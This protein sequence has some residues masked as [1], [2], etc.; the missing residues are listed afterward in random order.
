MDLLDELGIFVDD[1]ANWNNGAPMSEEDEE[2]LRIRMLLH[3]QTG[4]SKDDPEDNV[5]YFQYPLRDGT[6]SSCIHVN[7]QTMDPGK[8]ELPSVAHPD[9]GPVSSSYSAYLHAVYGWR[10]LDRVKDSLLPDD[11]KA[12]ESK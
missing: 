12:P 10:S 5:L 3:T 1:F 2:P 7:E 9:D 11:D 6:R 8:T 4:G